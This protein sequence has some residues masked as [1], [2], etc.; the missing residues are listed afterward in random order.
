LYNSE[1]SQDFNNLVQS[2]SMSLSISWPHLDAYLNSCTFVKPI[3]VYHLLSI[4]YA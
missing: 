4:I 2:T 3:D 1:L